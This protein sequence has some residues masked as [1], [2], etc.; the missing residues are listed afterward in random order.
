[1]L[2]SQQRPGPVLCNKQLIA[3]FWFLLPNSLSV[4]LSPG[5]GF[6]ICLR[7]PPT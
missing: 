7:R 6:M 2:S 5:A 3:N 1:M 4:A